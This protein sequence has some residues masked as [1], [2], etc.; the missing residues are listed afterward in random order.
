MS[1]QRGE[2]GDT[3][4]GVE[5][6]S[7]NGKETTRGTG[8]GVVDETMMKT[9]IREGAGGIAMMMMKESGGGIENAI[10][11]NMIGTDLKNEPNATGTMRR[12]GD[13]AEAARHDVMKID[14]TIALNLRIGNVKTKSSD[15]IRGLRRLDPIDNAQRPI[16]CN[17]IL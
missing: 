5:R 1:L 12:D 9:G 14:T 17:R 8:R 15:V 16:V 7:R 4:K 3:E 10:G 2:I 6:G 13:G 11:Q